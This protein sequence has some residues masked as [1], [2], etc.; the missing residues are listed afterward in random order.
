MEA[1]A[2]SSKMTVRTSGTQRTWTQLSRYISSGDAS[3]SLAQS[4]KTRKGTVTAWQV[5]CYNSFTVNC[6]F[7]NN[8]FSSGSGLLRPG[9][10]SGVGGPGR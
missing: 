2:L 8:T 3:F 1:L 5:R 4:H 7:K 9:G 10:G 6:A